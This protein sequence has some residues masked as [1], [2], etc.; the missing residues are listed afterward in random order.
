M[1]KRRKKR[2]VLLNLSMVISDI[3]FEVSEDKW[4]RYMAGFGSYWFADSVLGL[5]HVLPTWGSHLA[6]RGP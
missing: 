4:Q 3:F 6:C 1:Q 5:E 2:V